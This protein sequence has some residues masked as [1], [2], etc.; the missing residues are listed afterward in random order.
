[1]SHFDAMKAKRDEKHGDIESTEEEAI[2]T[3]FG[4]DV[5]LPLTPDS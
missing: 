3:A 2:V 5:S 4:D 1:M